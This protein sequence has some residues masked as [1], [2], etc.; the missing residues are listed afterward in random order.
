MVVPGGP[1]RFDDRGSAVIEA[2]LVSPI[3]LIL[4]LAVFDYGLLFRDYL[5]M[6]DAVGDAT[7]A[8]AVQGNRPAFIDDGSGNQ[9]GVTA[10]FVIASTMRQGLVGLPIESITG[11][12]VFRAGGPALGSP[13]EQVPDVCKNGSSSVGAACNYYN[14]RDAFE[15]V[16]AGDGSFFQCTGGS[17]SAC[18]WPPGT[19]EDGPSVMDID[20]LGVYLEIDR[21]FVTGI[22]GD[23]Q[24]L[25]YAAIQ[26]LEPGRLDDV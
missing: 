7:R 3:V 2:A 16:A 21:S 17:G 26:R 24:N 15:A 18:G 23:E 8:G 1:R 14:A 5:T 6:G 10:D 11:I 20:Y 13:L 25:E 9:V 19:R 4:L 22:V 12:V